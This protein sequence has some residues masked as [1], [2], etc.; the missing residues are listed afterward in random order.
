MNLCV[1]EVFDAP[2][3]TCDGKIASAAGHCA[4]VAIV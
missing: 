1:S 4:K 3:L 2:L